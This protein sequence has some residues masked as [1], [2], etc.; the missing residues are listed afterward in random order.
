MGSQRPSA[1]HVNHEEREVESV[2]QLIMGVLYGRQS[3]IKGLFLMCVEEARI[4]E[5]VDISREVT[6]AADRNRASGGRILDYIPRDRPLSNHIYAFTVASM[7]LHE[8]F[9]DIIAERGHYR[10][11]TR[12]HPWQS[13]TR[14]N[15]YIPP[16]P[17]VRYVDRTQCLWTWADYFEATTG[18]PPLPA[19]ADNGTWAQYDETT[20]PPSGFEY[21]RILELE[22]QVDSDYWNNP[23]I[24]T[25][26]N[27]VLAWLERVPFDPTEYGPYET[28]PLNRAIAEELLDTLR[29]RFRRI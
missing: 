20:G 9:E 2:F 10:T 15:Q 27:H 18:L 29:E 11:F 25:N 26:R 13:V 24:L 21:S 17:V 12:R 23:G 28:P 22:W 1:L 6:E 14:G 7:R 4:S 8:Q 16:P 3:C 5:I 19:W